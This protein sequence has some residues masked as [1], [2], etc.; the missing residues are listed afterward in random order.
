MIRNDQEPATT[1]ERVAE[2]ER[3][4]EGLRETARRMT[5]A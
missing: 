4:L 1:R 3:L 5:T 2:L